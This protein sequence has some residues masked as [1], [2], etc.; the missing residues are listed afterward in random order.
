LARVNDFEVAEDGS[1]SASIPIQEGGKVIVEINAKGSWEIEVSAQR[2]IPVQ[3]LP[4]LLSL[5]LL[6]WGIWRKFQE[7]PDDSDI[8]EIVENA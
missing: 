8:A 6:I 1:L 7:G 5:L 2:Q 4:T 3:F